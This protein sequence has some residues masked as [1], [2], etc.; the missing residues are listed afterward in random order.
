MKAPQ[1]RRERQRIAA[2]SDRDVE[3]LTQTLRAEVP[4]GQAL[5]CI[6]ERE[7]KRRRRD[8]KTNTPPAEE[9]P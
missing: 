2:M 1:A 7:L 6:C 9:L 4:R 8:A 5:L 3:T